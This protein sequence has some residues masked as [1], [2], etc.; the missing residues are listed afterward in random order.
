MKESSETIIRH[1]MMFLILRV[2][3]LSETFLLKSEIARNFSFQLFR[4]EDSHQRATSN[5]LRQNGLQPLAQ[6][7][8]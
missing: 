4:D 1:K 6:L 7:H 8:N 3:K 2:K 5:L